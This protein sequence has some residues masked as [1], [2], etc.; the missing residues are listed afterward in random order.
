MTRAT[1]LWGILIIP[2]ANSSSLYGLTL[3]GIL[4]PIKTVVYFLTFSLY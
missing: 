2:E 4:Q 3:A 1:E